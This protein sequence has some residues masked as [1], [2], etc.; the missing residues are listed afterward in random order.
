MLS[1]LQLERVC[2]LNYGHEQCRYLDGDEHDRTKFHCK[3]LSPERKIID[4]ELSHFLK[5]KKKAGED[6]KKEGVALGNGGGCKG[7]VVLNTKLQ[8][9][10]VKG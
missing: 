6:P 4:E 3:K 2:L 5:E 8:G 1:K 10:D 9:Y 7:F